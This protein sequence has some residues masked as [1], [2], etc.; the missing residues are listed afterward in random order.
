MEEK[1]I[2]QENKKRGSFELLVSDEPADIGDFDSLNV[3]VEEIRL[4]TA[5]ESEEPVVETLE[6]P[7]TVDLTELTGDRAE[8]ILKAMIPAGNYTKVEVYV[9]DQFD[10]PGEVINTPG[11]VKQS[12]VDSEQFVDQQNVQVMV[13]SGKLQIQKNFTIAPNSTVSFVFDMQVVLKGSTG[14]YNLQPNIGESGVEGEDVREQERVN[15]P[16]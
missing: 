13:P 14:E 12:V 11:R 5:N 9:Q 4:E 10:S 16:E 15:T 2:R 1:L 6:E 7:K 3:T 8:E